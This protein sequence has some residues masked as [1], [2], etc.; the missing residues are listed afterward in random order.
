[1]STI[2]VAIIIVGAISAIFLFLIKI[3]NKHNR[4]AMKK[5]LDQFSRSA[6]EANLSISSQEILKECIFGLDGTHRKIVVVHME[7]GS[8]QTN[9]I[10]LRQYKNCAVKKIYGTIQA[11]DL[12]SNK[13]DH[14]L[15]KIIV[16]FEAENNPS[17]EI[18]FYNHSVNHIYET[19]DMEKKAREWQ[20]ILSK[21]LAP[22]KKTA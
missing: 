21:L 4:E 19:L 1:M 9:I 20:A 14:F 13:L 18:A 3:N 2:I 12:K 17:R 8:P 15:E 6:T 10:E 7:N 5:L 11:G 16:E 22:L